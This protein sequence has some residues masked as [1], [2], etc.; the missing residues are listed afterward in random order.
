MPLGARR[1]TG[2]PARP[3]PRAR[4]RRLCGG[5]P[6]PRA[7]G[8][9]RAGPRTPHLAT[10]RGL[11]RAVA[12]PRRV[13]GGAR[14]RRPGRMAGRRPRRAPTVCDRGRCPGRRWERCGF[15]PTDRP[16]VLPFRATGGRR[17]TTS[18]WRSNPAS[19][20]V[21]SGRPGRAST[22]LRALAGLVPHFHGGRFSGRVEVGGRETRTTR[23]S[24]LA[25]T[26]ATVFQDPGT[27]SS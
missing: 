25:G 13:D 12:E 22:L 4:R 26:V 3:D 18:R 10:R 20:S 14:V 1:R 7:R 23:P 17:W 11:A 21:C 19:S 24:D 15:S 2:H 27:R 16:D 8:R 5:A 6:G 9:G